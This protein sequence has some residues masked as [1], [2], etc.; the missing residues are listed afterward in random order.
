[1]GCNCRKNN[2]NND[3]PE[4]RKDEI[5]ETN[6]FDFSWIEERKSKQTNK[7]TQSIELFW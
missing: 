3:E 6:S 7:A 2:M 1:M 5:K 4:F